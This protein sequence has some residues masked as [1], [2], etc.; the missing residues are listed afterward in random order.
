[1]LFLLAAGCTLPE[2]LEDPALR[3]G[4]PTARS[5]VRLEP[6]WAFEQPVQVTSPR[7]DG[8]LF[9]VER[10]GRVKIWIDDIVLKTPFLDLSSIV[11]T[12]QEQG[13]L[14]IAFPPD[15]RWSRLVYASYT[16]LVGNNRIDEFSVDRS[17]PNR[18]DPNTRR[19]ILTVKQTSPINNGGLVGFDSTGMLL[20]AIG[21]D[22]L[23][24]PAQDQRLL[25]GKFLRIDPKKPSE[26]RP[27]SIPE[28][29]PFASVEGARAEIWA[30]GLRNP[31]RWSFDPDTD[32]LYVTDVGEINY[33]P[34]PSQA[35]ANYGWPRYEGH[36]V[37][38]AG[39]AIA[40]E[41]LVDPILTFAPG[42][43]E[44][45]IIGGSVYRGSVT[46]IRGT[47]T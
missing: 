18:V 41:R 2:P 22:G 19:L 24:A 4:D 35:G 36:E 40:E 11:T 25:L 37:V 16:D 46:A 32:D 29:N 8:R 43:N 45:A 14:S 9:V 15:F 28:D 42:G 10:T 31:W 47:Y 27:Y 3:L 13:L 21:D 34:K 23:R 20:V 1:V 44:C 12:G 17:N 26:G 5:E 33:V 38:D 30:Y 6:I 7:A 39:R